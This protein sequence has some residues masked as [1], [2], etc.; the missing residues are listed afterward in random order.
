[1]AGLQI[2]ISVRGGLFNMITPTQTN[3]RKTSILLCQTSCY[4]LLRKQDNTSGLGLESR[5]CRAAN[6]TRCFR[7]VI[8]FV[9][10]SDMEHVLSSGVGVSS[11]VILLCVSAG[12]LVLKTSPQRNTWPHH[13]LEASGRLSVNGDKQISV[14]QEWQD[15]ISHRPSLFD[16][17]TMMTMTVVMTTETMMVTR[18]RK[19]N[20]RSSIGRPFNAA[21]YKGTSKE[22]RPLGRARKRVFCTC[23]MFPTTYQ[24][25][26][27]NHT[28][29]KICNTLLP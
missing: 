25:C 15:K 19:C 29:Q 21:V 4:R 10:L 3:K 26:V 20:R 22:L 13:T 27:N 28:F 8:S 9:C 17:T 6:A 7:L 24:Q 11:H 23:A 16:T 2:R 12:R 1:M 18:W 14:T 5:S